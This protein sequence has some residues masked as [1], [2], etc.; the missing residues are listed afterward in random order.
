MKNRKDQYGEI[1]DDVPPKAPIRLIII[2]NP[3]NTT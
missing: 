2:M 1:T 3:A